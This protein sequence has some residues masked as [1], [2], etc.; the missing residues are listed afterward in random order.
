ML[1]RRIARFMQG[2]M[3]WETA[4]FGEAAE[5][6]PGLR[7]SFPAVVGV[8]PK[9]GFVYYYLLA[10]YLRGLVGWGLSRGRKQIV[11][12]VARVLEEWPK[13]RV[14]FVYGGKKRG[15]FH[16]RRWEAAVEERTDGSKVVRMDEA[17]H[18]LHVE[19]AD[20]TNEMISAWLA[21]TAG[22]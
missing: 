4:T 11:P 20:E 3:L 13:C 21:A 16:D 7:E 14:L 22:Q 18:W 12:G 1:G 2:K 17:G 15:M 6:R 5:K 8:H 19:F 10:S 9:A